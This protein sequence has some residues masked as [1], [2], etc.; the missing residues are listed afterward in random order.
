MNESMHAWV[1]L[2]DL[3]QQMSFVPHGEKEL[4][5][6]NVTVK[7]TYGHKWDSDIILN[8]EYNILFPKWN[9]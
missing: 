3:R 7:I 6:I 4:K 1:M 8:S 2:P 5:S 9:T